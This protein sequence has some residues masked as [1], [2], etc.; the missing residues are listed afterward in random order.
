MP[1]QDNKSKM[2]IPNQPKN[3]AMKLV[4]TDISGYVVGPESKTGVKAFGDKHP[5]LKTKNPYADE[6]IQDNN[7]TAKNIKKDKTT[8]A[9][10]FEDK[11][12]KIA[13][14]VKR[15]KKNVEKFVRKF[16][17]AKAHS[18][19]GHEA[20]AAQHETPNKEGDQ[21]TSEPSKKVKTKTPKQTVT[22][23][24]YLQELGEPMSAAPATSDSPAFSGDSAKDTSGSPKEDNSSDD[25]TDEDSN[26][27]EDESVTKAKDMLETIAT[28]A[29]ELFEN[30]P[31][32]MK[33]PS[34]VIEK[35]DLAKGFVTSV[36]EYVSDSSNE[37]KDKE[38]GNPDKEQDNTPDQNPKPTAFKGGQ[39]TLAKEEVYSAK[40]ARH[41]ADIGKPGKNFAKIAKKA[42]EKYGSKE[43]GEKVAGAILAKIRSKHMGK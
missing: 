1:K 36:N 20:S 28:E 30:I 40:A 37:T 14:D 6:T 8:V 17:D 3:L 11:E 25:D 34:W 23:E 16:N 43:S 21:A 27:Q 32:D 33:L 26:D 39:G 15:K 12:D 5:V 38:E 2:A 4:K 13:H 9:A 35:L 42:S 24:A 7:A 10:D 18:L 29:A 41:G 31:D 22:S 19:Q